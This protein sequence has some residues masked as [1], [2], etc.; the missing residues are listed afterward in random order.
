MFERDV[1]RSLY[2]YLCDELDETDVVPAFEGDVII[3]L[4]T[5]LCY[6]L[7]ETDV[8][9]AFEGDGAG[10]VEQGAGHLVGLHLV[11]ARRLHDDRLPGTQLG[12]Q[13]LDPKTS[14]TKQ[15]QHAT[16]ANWIQCHRQRGL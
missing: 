9:P 6:E 7:D 8:V 3:S 13:G 15:Q 1:I 12:E 10:D 5:Y 4:Y 11:G 2:T 14:T 16:T